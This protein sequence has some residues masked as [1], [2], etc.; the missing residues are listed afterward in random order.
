[1]SNEAGERAEHGARAAAKRQLTRSLHALCNGMWKTVS[2]I[3]IV[4]TT[5]S[6]R[7]CFLCCP[8]LRRG[9]ITLELSCTGRSGEP[10]VA[11]LGRTAPA[12]PAGAAGDPEG[13]EE[14]GKELAPT[15]MRLL[16]DTRA[17]FGLRG[18]GGEGR[19]SGGRVAG[20]VRCEA[21]AACHCAL[22]PSLVRRLA[23]GLPNLNSHRSPWHFGKDE[24]KRVPGREMGGGSWANLAALGCFNYKWGCAVRPLKCHRGSPR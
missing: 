10:I 11:D 16:G 12:T 21:G 23:S 22:R 1:V 3:S 6:F 15:A 9:K 24:A 8:C 17:C 2:R 19:A 5:P 7:P 20:A 14:V 13:G 18:G 4:T